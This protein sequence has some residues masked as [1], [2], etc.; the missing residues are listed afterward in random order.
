VRLVAA[1]LKSGERPP[2]NVLELGCGTGSIVSDVAGMMP[3]SA[4]WGIDV[5]PGL[6][7]YARE[8]HAAPNITFLVGDATSALPRPFDGAYSIDVLHHIADKPRLLRT[9]RS[10]LSPGGRWI[11]IEPNIFHPYV[12][13]QQQAMR[14]AGL[15]EHHFRP[16]KIVPL[17][18]D[19]G[20]EV[21]SRMYAHLFPATMK[22]VGPL[23]SRLERLVE[24][25][26]F[27]GGS[28]VLI[29]APR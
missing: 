11:I 13:W 24:G 28:L 3:G 25:V 8:R 19:T 9:V 29:V 23:L 2:M 27:V 7:R 10:A 1:G 17:L 12:T 21:K 14:R 26:P 18:R 5:D 16:W 15:D 20:F 4:F 22:N 6:I